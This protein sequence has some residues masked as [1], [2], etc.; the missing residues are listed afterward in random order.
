MPSHSTTPDWSPTVQSNITHLIDDVQC[1]Q[2]VRELRW[3]DG[4]T[5]P[6]GASQ[7]SAK[8]LLK[9]KEGLIMRTLLLMLGGGSGTPCLKPP[10]AEG[11]DMASGPLPAPRIP[12]SRQGGPLGGCHTARPAP[13]RRLTA[14]V[15]G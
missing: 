11:R 9:G 10:P 7:L 12:A 5:C 3:P 6:S 15:H 8:A 4:I 2:S 14:C 13:A 1:Y